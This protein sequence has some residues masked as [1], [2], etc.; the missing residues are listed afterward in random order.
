VHYDPARPENAGVGRAWFA[1]LLALVLAAFTAGTGATG[2]FITG[3]L[4]WAG[5]TGTEAPSGDSVEL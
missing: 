4:I 1:P 3:A 2:F 5:R